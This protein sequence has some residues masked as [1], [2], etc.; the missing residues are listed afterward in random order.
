[1]IGDNHRH[2]LAVNLALPDCNL[3][4]LRAAFQPGLFSFSG[5]AS[6]ALVRNLQP[7]RDPG[8]N[9]NREEQPVPD[10]LLMLAKP[11]AFVCLAGS[12][13]TGHF[14]DDMKRPGQTLK[15]AR[16]C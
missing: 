12:V 2:P 8:D 9:R 14:A 13:W 16:R 6:I 5:L 4:C 10:R 3:V 1:V 7:A 15:R 11:G